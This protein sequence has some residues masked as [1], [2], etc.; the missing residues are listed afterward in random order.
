M[1]DRVQFTGKIIF[2]SCA[3]EFLFIRILTVSAPVHLYTRKKFQ[4]PELSC[5]FQAHGMLV[6]KLDPIKNSITGKLAMQASHFPG[7]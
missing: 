6:E 5:I 7:R 2:P 4:G 1:D 3:T